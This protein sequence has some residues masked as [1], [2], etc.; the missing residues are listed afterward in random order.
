MS[1]FGKQSYSNRGDGRQALMLC[2]KAAAGCTVIWNFFYCLK[3][4]NFC[5]LRCYVLC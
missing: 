5:N 3:H 1:K 4:D 2:E